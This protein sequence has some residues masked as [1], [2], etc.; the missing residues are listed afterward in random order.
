MEE[1]KPT[2]EGQPAVDTKISNREEASKMLDA[3]IDGK[4]SEESQASDKN[5]DDKVADPKGD[6][7]PA[8]D[9][10]NDKSDNKAGD[11]FSKILSNRNKEKNDL[12]KQEQEKLIAERIKE[13][14]KNVPKTEDKED[15]P[16]NESVEDV[17]RRVMNEDKEKEHK[18][19]QEKEEMIS[20]VKI[21]ITSNPETSNF[22][23]KII[24]IME[25][26]PTLNAYAAYILASHNAPSDPNSK[27]STSSKPN[28]AL[29]QEK[30]PS[31]M[32]KEELR[33]GASKELEKML[34]L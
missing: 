33:N 34:Q 14:T 9:N 30:T 27:T 6:V 7:D 2:T 29:R 26:H 4:S 24:Q 10:S 11:D 3:I 23:A 18:T 32:T 31:N 17:V 21:F 1:I 16:S 15:K 22:E 19:Q 12:A 28:S 8:K 25:A 20:D 5:K 13:E